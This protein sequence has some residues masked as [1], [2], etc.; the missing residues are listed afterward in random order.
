MGTMPK[1][2]VDRSHARER[3]PHWRA[4]ERQR[5]APAWRVHLQLSDAPLRVSIADGSMRHHAQ[6]QK[7]GQQPVT[8]HHRLFQ[9]VLAGSWLLLRLCD[10]LVR[11]CVR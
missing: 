10:L 9:L 7:R 8:A 5:L 2:V 3:A 1:A 6:A 11:R 4:A